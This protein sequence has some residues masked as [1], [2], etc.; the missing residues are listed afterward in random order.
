MAVRIDGQVIDMPQAVRGFHRY[1]SQDRA[2]R[3]ASFRLTQGQRV[4]IGEAFWTHPLCPGVCYPTR[5]A[6]NRAALAK[7]ATTEG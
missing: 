1:G 5:I 3:A 7:L 4:S 2:D 6:A